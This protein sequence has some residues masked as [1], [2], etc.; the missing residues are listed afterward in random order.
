MLALLRTAHFGAAASREM[1]DDAMHDAHKHV[2]MPLIPGM[3]LNDGPTRA[4]PRSRALGRSTALNVSLSCAHRC[5]AAE[6]E[7]LDL[8]TR[9][10]S[11]R[12]ELARLG[13]SSGG[14]DSR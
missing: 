8:S 13:R 12:H 6:I 5:R 10:T 2:Q 1:S 11:S 4:R 3:G 9:L 14:G 7:R